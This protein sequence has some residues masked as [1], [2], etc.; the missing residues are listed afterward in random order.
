MSHLSVC[1][2]PRLISGPAFLHHEKETTTTKKIAFILQHL[3]VLVLSTYYII[4]I[5]YKYRFL[6]FYYYAH[7]RKH[8]S[9]GAELT[10]R[11]GHPG[12]IRRAS[13]LEA[14]Y[15]VGVHTCKVGIQQREQQEK[16]ARRSM[17]HEKEFA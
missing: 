4:Y 6:D 12:D 1:L 7:G 16:K 14:A 15:R 8:A 10:C 13:C 11:L 3:S 9:G 17:S 5:A 2:S